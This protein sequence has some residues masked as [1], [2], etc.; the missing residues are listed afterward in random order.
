MCGVIPATV[1]LIASKLLGAENAELVMYRTSGDVTGDYSQVVGYAGIII[2]SMRDYITA[3][4]EKIQ[5]QIDA[6]IA[7]V[8]EAIKKIVGIIEDKQ[9]ESV[10]SELLEWKDKALYLEINDM[11]DEIDDLVKLCHLQFDPTE[12]DKKRKKRKAKQQ[13]VAETTTILKD[14]EEILDE[15]S[16]MA[17]ATPATITF[18]IPAMAEEEIMPEF[19]SMKEKREFKRKIILRKR[20]RVH[21]PPKTTENLNNQVRSSQA[22]RQLQLYSQQINRPVKRSNIDSCESCGAKQ[23]TNEEKFCFFCGK[24]I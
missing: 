13:K 14:E 2:N 18:M 4:S 20:A 16:F 21:K 8:K 10:Y 19:S 9:A 3:T 5:N 1:G 24:M 6:D 17:S 11:V 7:S 12:K 15:T 23:P 22:R